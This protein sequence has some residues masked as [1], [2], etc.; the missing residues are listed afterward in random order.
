M[1]AERNIVAI[2]GMCGSGK[3]VVTE[4]FEALGYTRVYFGQVTMDEL[5]R[6]NL[7]RN[8]TNERR[9]REALRAEF[10]KAAFALKL[11]PKI[12][13]AMKTSNVVIDGL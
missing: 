12:T 13:E 6:Q 8:E 2:V 9:V 7:E 5:A 1:M 3:S 10:G 11:L 4:R